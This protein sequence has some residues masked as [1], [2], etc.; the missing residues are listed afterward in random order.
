MASKKGTG[1]TRN[2]RDSKAQRL[3]V[4]CYGGEVV[5]PGSIIVRQ[6]GTSFHPGNNVGLG[7]DY[8]IFARIGGIVAFER[9]GKNSKKVSVYPVPQTELTEPR[10]SSPID[11]SKAGSRMVATIRR[12]FKDGFR[13][14]ALH[15][16]LLDSPITLSEEFKIGTTKIDNVPNSSLLNYEELA[17]AYLNQILEEDRPQRFRDSEVDK[18]TYEFKLEKVKTSKI[19]GLTTL[20]FRQHYKDIPFYNSKLTVEMDKDRQLVSINSVIAETININTVP[21][22]SKDE[23][24]QVVVNAVS[25]SNKELLN[26]HSYVC[27]YY[28]H[29]NSERWKL[30]YIFQDI[31]KNNDSFEE[32]RFMPEVVDYVIDANNGTIVDELPRTQ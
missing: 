29:A 7:K 5:K 2:G 14:L 3:G 30:V 26:K 15:Y 27:L 24:L 12:D 18:L 1:S 21:K 11:L 16:K 13:M 32:H 10:S 4:K 6:R 17:I 9:K 28:E 20:W 31:T 19:T 22:I 8:T 25:S 23:A